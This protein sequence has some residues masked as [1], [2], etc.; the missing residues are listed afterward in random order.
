MHMQLAL[1]MLKMRKWNTQVW[2]M[3]HDVG[4]VKNARVKNVA[5]YGKGGKCGMMWQA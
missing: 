4:G 5:R 1:R 2:K 3:R